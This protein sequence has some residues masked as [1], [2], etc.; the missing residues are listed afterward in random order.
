ME[1]VNH[2]ISLGIESGM[3]SEKSMLEVFPERD[4]VHFDFQ[5]QSNDC[6]FE[7]DENSYRVSIRVCLTY[8]EKYEQPFALTVL[9][10]DIC[11]NTQAKLFDIIQCKLVGIHRQLFLESQ[12]LYL[13]FQMQKKSQI[14]QIGCDGCQIIQSPL[15]KD[16]L[17]K[18]RDFIL[19]NLSNNITIPIIA[20]AMGTNQ[21]YLKKGFKESFGQTSFEFIQENR[22]IKARYL[23]QNDYSISE[24]AQQ[25][26]YSSLS[27]FSQA[28]KNYFGINPSEHFRK[29]LS[30][31]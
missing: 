9:Q 16:K 6:L 30:N 20:T 19:N 3:P 29:L 7:L 15:E 24:V 5:L 1:W 22:M 11:C 17:L 31:N 25:V 10:Q 4:W 14:F 28:F 2:H 13:L 27:S 26:G 8:F 18:A 21:C 12:I 23:L